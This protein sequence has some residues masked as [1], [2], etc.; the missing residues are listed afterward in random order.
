M[1]LADLAPAEN[2]DAD[3]RPARNGAGRAPSQLHELGYC[4][5]VVGPELEFFLV[6]RDPDGAQRH[7]P[8]S[9]TT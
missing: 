7:R 1:C 2:G 8:G 5:P 6:R 3:R 9:S 4:D